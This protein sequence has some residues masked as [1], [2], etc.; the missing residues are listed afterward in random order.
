[1]PL[2]VVW[3]GRRIQEVVA[4]ICWFGVQF[5][6]HQSAIRVSDDPSVQKIR[7]QGEKFAGEFDGRVDT[8]Q[9]V[10]E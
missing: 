7:F 3:M 8:I 10:Y 2:A 9:V 4:G 1:M 6:H 5:R